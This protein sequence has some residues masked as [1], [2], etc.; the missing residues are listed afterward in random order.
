MLYSTILAIRISK[1]C[2]LNGSLSLVTLKLQRRIQ[3]YVDIITGLM[4]CVVNSTAKELLNL[5][6]YTSKAL[7]MDTDVSFFSDGRCGS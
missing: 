4:I 2:V 5:R 7:P 1:F 6:K 3:T